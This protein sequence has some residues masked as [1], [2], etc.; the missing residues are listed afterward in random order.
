VL[1]VELAHHHHALPVGDG[2]RIERPAALAELAEGLRR[3]VLLVGRKS[4]ARSMKQFLPII[5]GRRRSSWR[6]KPPP[7]VG[8]LHRKT[9][10]SAA[11]PSGGASDIDGRQVLGTSGASA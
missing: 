9:R 11:S 4:L 3:L 7:W 2:T 8:R 1:G 6:L 5:A 10:A